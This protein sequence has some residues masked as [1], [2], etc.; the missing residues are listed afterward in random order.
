M[1]LHRELV[2]RC[3]INHAGRALNMKGARSSVRRSRLRA[4]A[5]LVGESGRM[6]L[7]LGRLHRLL[8]VERGKLHRAWLGNQILTRAE[9]TCVEGLLR[10]HLRLACKHAAL[11]LRPPLLLLLQK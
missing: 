3:I 1:G 9:L 6:S 8:G 4:K 5:L 7:L 11:V 2:A 10:L